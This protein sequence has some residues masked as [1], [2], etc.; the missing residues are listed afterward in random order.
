MVGGTLRTTTNFFLGHRVKTTMSTNKTQVRSILPAR[1]R[2]A[3][4]ATIARDPAFRRYFAS[5]D[6]SATIRGVLKQLYGAAGNTKRSAALDRQL[7]RE[8][9]SRRALV[10]ARQRRHR[11][12]NVAQALAPVVQAADSRAQRL[13]NRKARARALNLLRRR[14]LAFRAARNPVG[15]DVAVRYQNTQKARVYATGH[16]ASYSDGLRRAAIDFY[17]SLPTQWRV[18]GINLSIRYDFYA[19]NATDVNGNFL[20]PEHIRNM[21]FTQCFD[22]DGEGWGA[23]YDHDM[24]RLEEQRFNDDRRIVSLTGLLNQVE[25]HLLDRINLQELYSVLGTTLRGNHVRPLFF[26]PN[27]V[28]FSAHRR[29]FDHEQAIGDRHSYLFREILDQNDTGHCVWS[30]MLLQQL[31]LNTT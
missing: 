22:S 25:N 29:R 8:A 5:G 11:A 12:Q 1:L 7:A 18:E 30:A 28:V 21:A 4:F 2:D 27:H 13:A 14:Q 23:Y 26:Q 10:G 3:R 20:Y 16:L 31:A 17:Q 6:D 9:R 19:S 15:A 24:T